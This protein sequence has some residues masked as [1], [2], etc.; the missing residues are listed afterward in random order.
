MVI[1]ALLLA[2]QYQSA[3]V[4]RVAI[5]EVNHYF[6]EHG[7]RRFTQLIGWKGHVE[8]DGFVFHA[9]WWRM[10]K[11]DR[12]PTKDY[13]RGVWT[14]VFRDGNNL[15]KIVADEYRETWTQ[16]DPEV[17]DREKMA[18]SKRTGLGKGPPNANIPAP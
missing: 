11:S 10:W 17:D 6:D 3:I 15:R 13:A 7:N 18:M 2:S 12:R 1:L 4:C 14:V 9:H 8:E 16:H 5:V